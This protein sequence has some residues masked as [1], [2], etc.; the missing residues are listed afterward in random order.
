MQQGG[1]AQNFWFW[2]RC[3]DRVLALGSAGLASGHSRDNAA[4]LLLRQ[5]AGPGNPGGRSPVPSP[6]GPACLLVV[7]ATG[8]L[9]L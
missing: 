7:G 5:P 8:F 1:W 6:A 2:K 4:S 3:Q 9:V